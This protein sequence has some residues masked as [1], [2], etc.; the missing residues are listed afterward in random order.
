MTDFGAALAHWMQVRGVGVRE[1]HRRSGYSVGYVSQL[2]H[3]QR[4]PSPEAARDLDDALGARGELA[5]AAVPPARRPPACRPV[6]NPGR[7]RPPLPAS[8]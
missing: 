1:L 5:R 8:G 6:P 7:P 2:R 3:G 4:N